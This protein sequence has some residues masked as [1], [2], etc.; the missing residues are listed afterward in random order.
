LIV[1]FFDYYPFSTLSNNGKVHG[2]AIKEIGHGN[3]KLDEP[4]FTL[5]KDSPFLEGQLSF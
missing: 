3:V 2:K 4:S 1:E 5:K